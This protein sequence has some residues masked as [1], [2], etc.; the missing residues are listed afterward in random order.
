LKNN[1]LIICF[2]IASIGLQLTVFLFLDRKAD[3]LLNPSYRFDKEYSID[4]SLA[5]AEKY[6]LSYNNKFLACVLKNNLK[7]VDLTNNNVFNINNNESIFMGYKWLPDRNGLIYFTKSST[8]DKKVINLYSLDLETENQIIPKL[9]RTVSIDLEEIL[10]IEISTYTNN[11]YILSKTP[12]QETELIKID[13][14]KNYVKLNKPDEPII[15]IS[16]SNKFG[17]LFVES[18]NKDKKKS[19][20][21][22]KSNER[23]LICNDPNMVLLECSDNLLYIGKLDN[24]YL[25]QVYLYMLDNTINQLSANGGYLIWQGYIPFKETTSIICSDDNLLLK[26][27]NS[28]YIIQPN[29]K[30]K[31]LDIRNNII[32]ASTGLMYMELL[33]DE[34][35]TTYYWR[36]ISI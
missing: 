2:I 7:I 17:F 6:S 33:T 4:E 14:M 26:S 35:K 12:N 23:T 32:P 31:K 34:F 20:T 10:E 24:G 25:A 30:L 8:N 11:L 28:L 27:T 22:L 29:G 5:D 18:L 16:V 9:D 36:S 21:M 3:Q 1:K 19:I 15:R 13:L